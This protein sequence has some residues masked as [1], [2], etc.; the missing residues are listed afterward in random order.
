MRLSSL[1]FVAVSLLAS[2]SCVGENPFSSR[3]TSAIALN[4]TLPSGEAFLDR[5]TRLGH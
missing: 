2:F 4:I 1:L 5:G 3:D